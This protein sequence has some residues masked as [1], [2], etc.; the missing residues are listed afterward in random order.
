MRL[1]VI[2]LKANCITLDKT[3]SKRLLG[4]VVYN[5]IMSI[6]EILLAFFLVFIQFCN[7]L[8]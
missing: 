7:N 1:R 8:E 4:I 5:N 3:L 2:D 6:N